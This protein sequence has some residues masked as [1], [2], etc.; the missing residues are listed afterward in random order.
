MSAAI[1]SVGRNTQLNP[2]SAIHTALNL[3]TYVC[4]YH[5][6][7]LDQDSNV[8]C[9]HVALVIIYLGRHKYLLCEN[10]SAQRASLCH[11][12]ARQCKRNMESEVVRRHSVP[13]PLRYCGSELYTKDQSYS[14]DNAPPRCIRHGK[15]AV[16][17]F[18]SSGAGIRHPK[19]VCTFIAPLSPEV[20]Q[21]K[22]HYRIEIKIWYAK[23]KFKSKDF[24]ITI[25]YG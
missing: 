9:L 16:Y 7:G 25:V 22:I 6:A 15:R 13:T 14:N 23:H 10:T 5:A 20:H 18:L 17:C 1:E 24:Q 3:H 2:C 12:G 11:K 8:A 4:T 19:S 21:R